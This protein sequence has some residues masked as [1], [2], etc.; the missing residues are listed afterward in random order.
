MRHG[1]SCDGRAAWLAQVGRGADSQ[2]VQ[3]YIRCTEQIAAGAFLTETA[4]KEGNA[5]EKIHA[6][7]FHHFMTLLI[8]QIMQCVLESW[9]FFIVEYI[10]LFHDTVLLLCGSFE[11]IFQR[12]NL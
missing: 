6:T 7:T 9:G 2:A 12:K 5:L 10:R 4:R 11:T 8:C 1:I 3:G